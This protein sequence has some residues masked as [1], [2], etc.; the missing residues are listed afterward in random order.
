MM[1]RHSLSLGAAAIALALSVT[2]CSAPGTFVE[3]TLTG[4]LPGDATKIVLN[5]TL[6][7]TSEDV[8]ITKL[9]AQFPSTAVLQIENGEGELTIVGQ[10]QTASGVA[11]S[12]T[13]SQKVTVV[14][15]K[16]VKTTLLFPGKTMNGDMAPPDLT[17]QPAP[18]LT[19]QPAPDLRGAPD[20]AVPADLAVELD[21]SPP[22]DLTPVPVAISLTKVL[23]GNA[24]GEVKLNGVSCTPTCSDSV[25]P[26]T[27]ITLT[28]T[29]DP[30]FGFEGWPA[31]L[32]GN[33]V[34]ATS[35]CTMT[36][37]AGGNLD[38]RIAPF[39][40]VFFTSS[41]YTGD[42]KKNGAGPVLDFDA[43][44]QAAAATASL[45]EANRYKAYFST[46]TR[47]AIEQLKTADG[48]D[49]RGWVRMDKLPFADT[50]LDLAS[51]KIYYPVLFNELNQTA[52]DLVADGKVSYWT[53]TGSGNMLDAN[54]VDF[55]DGTVNFS[56]QRGSPVAGGNA[57]IDR[58]QAAQC[59]VA[60]PILCFG[61]AFR[62]LLFRPQNTG[63][64]VFLS[65]LVTN[66]ANGLAPF[67]QTCRT[68]AFNAGLCTAAD[69]TC[70]FSAALATTTATLASRFGADAT[71]YVRT[72]GVIVAA[73]QTQLFSGTWKAPISV[74]A[75]QVY[76]LRADVLT[77]V[78]SATNPS[79][80]NGISSST[81][82]NW[83]G[84]SK[85]RTGDN[86]L[87]NIESL[88]NKQPNCSD[89]AVSTAT[90]DPTRVYC[91]GTP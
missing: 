36:V 12:T 48:A 55:T 84:A 60:Q 33:C 50:K 6:G 25:L 34:G 57:W 24:T 30:D 83:S 20:L 65:S 52:F 61:T 63:R 29:P 74:A 27:A 90:V 28:A 21:L 54:C 11:L 82:S 3:L 64:T 32:S 2:A 87:A 18:D 13:A 1:N 26:G 78:P 44:C 88:F 22:A 86:F 58:G 43:E 15:D 37:G 46:G 17:G 40:R 5:L 45:P 68:D 71:Q 70:K 73:D 38:V 31:G 14:R 72:D 8:T 23:L 80:T 9:P 66:V 62:P 51:R 49:S 59:S 91:F 81:C 77:G 85:A 79:T 41:I 56:G 76:P 7:G 19:G 4:A 67:D 10:L 47:I 89:I 53:G 35:P 75:N 16:S 39:N 69:A 42:R